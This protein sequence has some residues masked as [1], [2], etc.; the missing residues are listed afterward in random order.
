MR[1]HSDEQL[2][3]VALDVVEQ[4]GLLSVGIPDS[5]LLMV[6]MPLALSDPKD[7][8]K[9][10]DDKVVVLYGEYPTKGRTVNGYPMCFSMKY[11]TD[12]DWTVLRPMIEKLQTSI[13]AAKAAL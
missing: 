7:I 8:K 6:F 3:A 13:A 12:E 1:Y 9:M 10:Q 2:K 4:R 11:F 5:L